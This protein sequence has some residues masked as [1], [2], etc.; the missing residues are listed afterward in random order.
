MAKNRTITLRE[1]IEAPGSGKEASK[2]ITEWVLREPKY[3]DLMLLGEPQAYGRS[4]E[5]IM[6][7]SEKD[8]VLDAY[9]RRLTVTPQDRALLD[10]LCLA[11]TIQLR[12]AVFGFFKAARV[13]AFPPSSPDLS[14]T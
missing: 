4:E 8:D 2:Q 3:P 1:P 5:G 7:T 6:F 13:A 14:S 9:V 10:Q 12:E 11:D